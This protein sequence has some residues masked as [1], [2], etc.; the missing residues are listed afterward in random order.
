MGLRSPLTSILSP[1]WG[2]GGVS[3][4]GDFQSLLISTLGLAWGRGGV[5]EEGD[6]Q[7]PHHLYPLPYM[8]ERARVRGSN[9]L[10]ASMSYAQLNS[11]NR[12]YPLHDSMIEGTRR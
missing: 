3:A 2:R 1:T 8:G 7:S 11:C 9:T 10:R 6:F 4:E 5:S 12:M